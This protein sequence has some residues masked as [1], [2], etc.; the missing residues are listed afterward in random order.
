MPFW[1]T[2]YETDDQS[3]EAYEQMQADLAITWISRYLALLSA[4]LE[5]APVPTF[6]G[7]LFTLADGW[8]WAL[9]TNDPERQLLAAQLAE[10]LTTSEY[11][12]AWSEAA[13]LIPPR[14]SALA[15]WGNPVQK[16]LL[17]QIAP[18]A[19]MPPSFDV[20]TILGPVLQQAAVSVL[21]AEADAITAA[22]AAVEKVTVP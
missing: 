22:Q 8:V 9:T 21:K 17:E 7:N 16:A 1:L 20:I 3:W 11:L 18:S 5:A 14:P 15:A 13:G 10:F 6:D 2:Q 4:D 12:A 19:Q